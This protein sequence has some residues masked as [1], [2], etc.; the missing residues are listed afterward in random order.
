MSKKTLKMGKGGH[1]SIWPGK[2][3]NLAANFFKVQNLVLR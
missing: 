2:F 3:Q 1:I